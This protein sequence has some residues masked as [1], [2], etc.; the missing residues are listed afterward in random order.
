MFG[1]PDADLG[2]TVHAVVVLAGGNTAGPGLADELLTHLHERLAKYKCPAAIE[3]ATELPR[4][5]TG[6]LYKRLLKDA[7]RQEA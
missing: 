6:K 7:Y 1:I 2:E 4:H 3:F 5:A